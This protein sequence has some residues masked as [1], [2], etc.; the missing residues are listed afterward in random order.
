MRDVLRFGHP[1]RPPTAWTKQDVVG[2]I[3]VV[4]PW[5]SL[6]ASGIEASTIADRRDRTT[7]IVEGLDTARPLPELAASADVCLA[8]LSEAGRVVAASTAGAP[9]AVGSVASIHASGGGVP[10]L[11][12]QGAN[13]GWRGIEGDRQRTRKHHGRVWQAL[14]IWSI[15]CIDCLVEEGHPIAPGCAG[16]NLT[17]RG[18][19]LATLR[20]G[21][22][23]QVGDVVCEISVP[24]LP[25]SKI[26]PYFTGGDFLRVH[27]ELHPGWSR[28]YATVV[29]PGDVEIGDPVVVEP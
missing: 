13:V 17:L 28:L 23:V 5:W 18:I 8:L 16:E 6:L 11:P 19:D 3:R 21:T 9:S 2:T 1:D 26:I 15:E 25:C 4:E 12:V 10:K 29:R 20:P 7:R 27:H 14:C 22:L 24:A